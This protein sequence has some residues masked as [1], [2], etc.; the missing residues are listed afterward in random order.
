[1]V[2]KIEICRPHSDRAALHR[3]YKAEYLVFQSEFMH[4]HSARPWIMGVSGL[5]VQRIGCDGYTSHNVI[6]VKRFA[7]STSFSWNIQF[8][9]SLWLS[10]VK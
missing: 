1:M 5:T 7:H 6:R 2:I 8:Q 9:F 3:S 10:S 4:A